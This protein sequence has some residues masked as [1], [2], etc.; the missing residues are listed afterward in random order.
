M[1]DAAIFVSVTYAM[2]NMYFVGISGGVFFAFF[3]TLFVCR[4]R[5]VWQGAV[6]GLLTGLAFSPVYAPVFV[7]AGIAAGA[8]WSI[9]AF[10]ALTAASAAGMH[11]STAEKSACA[12]MRGTSEGESSATPF[13]PRE[14]TASPAHSVAAPRS[15]YKSA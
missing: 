5:G 1:P 8:L 6:V 4:R 15:A 13:S 10:G 2:R 9:S 12:R 11:K 14:S 3:I 7:M